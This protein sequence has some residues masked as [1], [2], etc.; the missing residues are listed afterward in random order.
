MHKAGPNHE[1]KALALAMA[2]ATVTAVATMFVPTVW[3]ESATG[4]TGLSELIP[5][6]AAPLGDTARALIAFGAGALALAVLALMLLHQA[7][8]SNDAAATPQPFDAGDSEPGLAAKLLARL[9]SV[10]L[11]QMPWAKSEGQITDLADLPRLRTGDVH[12]DAPPR[13]PLS[14]GIDLPVLDLV[15]PE[16]MPAIDPLQAA[17]TGDLAAIVI[18]QEPKPGLEAVASASHIEPVP[19][20][21]EEAQPTLA[22]MVAQLEHAVAERKKQLEALERTA[23][24]SAPAQHVAV[25]EEQSQTHDVAVPRPVLEA[26]NPAVGDDDMDSALAAALAT[27]HRM[28]RAA[29]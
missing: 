7:S 6:A 12:P 23:I 10:S 9:S 19:F 2:G 25:A 26:V 22:E 28:N 17:T 1:I 5:S 4:A 3:L 16:P 20:S 27:L 21:V 8:P 24:E 11:P 13:R 15:E 18:G 14:A 29:G